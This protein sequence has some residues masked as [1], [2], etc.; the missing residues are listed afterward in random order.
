MLVERRVSIPLRASATPPERAPRGP[1]TASEGV[2][3]VG[4]GSRCMISAEQMHVIGDQAQAAL[5]HL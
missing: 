2:L 1:A 4:H 5:P 3:L